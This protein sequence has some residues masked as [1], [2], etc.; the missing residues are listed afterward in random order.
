MISKEFIAKTK[1][2]LEEEEKQLTTQLQRFV[3]KTS[4]DPDDYQAK[5]PIY[6]DKED[7]NAAEVATFQDNLSLESN[8]KSSLKDV[9]RAL[10]SLAKHKYGQ[11]VKCKEEISQARL[12]IFPAA[13]L[14]VVCKNKEAV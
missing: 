13:A 9:R 7:E 2:R 3:E 5:F 14:C 8:L 11:C 12:E 6:G 1:K 4:Q 10:D